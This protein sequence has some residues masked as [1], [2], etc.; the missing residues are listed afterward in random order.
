MTSLGLIGA[1]AE[2]LIECTIRRCDVKFLSRTMS[3]LGTVSTM[4]LAA[5]SDTA[6]FPHQIPDFDITP[7]A[8]P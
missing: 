8:E 7:R 2:R 6:I 1:R 4:S 3:A 5:I